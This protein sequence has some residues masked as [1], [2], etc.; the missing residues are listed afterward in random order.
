MTFTDRCVRHGFFAVL[1]LFG[2][3][4]S[5]FSQQSESPSL[6]AATTVREA[7]KEQGVAPEM[8]AIPRSS[9]ELR[10]IV[11]HHLDPRLLNKNRSI[12][13]CDFLYQFSDPNRKVQL[14]V[15]VLGYPTARVTKQM[16]A[17]LTSHQNYFRNSKILIRY[18]VAPLGTLVVVSYSE[19]SG[20]KRIVETI[21]SL[22]ASFEK[23]SSVK[24]P[25]WKD[26]EIPDTP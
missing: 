7:L 21:D 25:A 26:S 2:A 1:L 16:V 23:A 15:I 5:V 3:V 8:K 20:D 18:S 11:S 17:I 24:G 19:N 12:S 14:G 6:F 13:G 9:S 10:K 4:Q 22:P